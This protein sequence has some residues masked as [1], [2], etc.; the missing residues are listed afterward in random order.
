M[1]NI[2][3]LLFCGICR[4]AT[5]IWKV[6]HGL[7]WRV[8]A[9]FQLRNEPSIPC[10]STIVR[11]ITY[12]ESILPKGPY[13]PCVSM[14][15]RALLAGYHRLLD[16]VLIPSIF[17]KML[18][19]QGWDTFARFMYFSVQIL[20]FFNYCQH[21]AIHKKTGLCKKKWDRDIVDFVV[22][23]YDCISIPNTHNFFL[24]ICIEYIP[25]TCP[26]FPFSVYCWVVTFSYQL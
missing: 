13:L 9:A 14:L 5:I 18:T 10:G 24:S 7:R 23:T 19:T 21:F 8:T 16:P 4:V 17:S 26:R 2:S 11:S 3:H 15:G 1:W 22:T 25:K 6:R 12:Y 20:I